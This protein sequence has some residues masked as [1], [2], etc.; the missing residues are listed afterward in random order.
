[1][2]RIARRS[3]LAGLGGAALAACTTRRSAPPTADG[4]GASASP[5]PVPPVTVDAATGP[6]LVP[7]EPLRVVVLDTDV[8]DSALTLGITPVGAALPAA[9]IRFPAYWPPPGSPGSTGSAWPAPRT[10]SRSGRCGLT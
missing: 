1:M 8:L 10:W 5:T 2:H 7:G 4:L 6:V 9:D 3:F